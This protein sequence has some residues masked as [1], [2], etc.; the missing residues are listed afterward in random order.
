MTES[1]PSI[2]CLLGAGYS[3]AAGIP[4]AKDLLRTG[5]LLARSQRA[6]NRFKLVRAHFAE[7]QEAHPLSHSEQYLG[8]IFNRSLG[9]NAPPWNW[10]VEYISAAIASVGTPLASLN[11]NPRYSNRVNRPTGC[12]THMYFWGT[13]LNHS[14]N[15]SVLTTNY[16]ILIERALRHRVMHRPPSPGCYYGGFSRPQVLKGAAQ[17]FSAWGPEK[18]IEMTG[19]VPIFKLHGSLNWSLEGGKVIMYQDA[20]A[21]FRK[22]GN[23]AIVP[24]VPE[25]SIPLWLKEVWEESNVALKNWDLYT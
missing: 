20:R 19:S 6:E 15:V 2:A 13:I 25:K 18:L 11:R 8:G 3:L 22:G 10:V 7:W 12:R 21:A 17:P 16:D 5:Y 9:D 1:E 4:L 14:H 23:A 24:P